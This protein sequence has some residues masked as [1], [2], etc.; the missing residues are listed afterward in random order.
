MHIIIW[1][2][3]KL[4][5]EAAM[6]AALALVNGKTFRTILLYPFAWW[7]KRSGNQLEQKLV[8]EAKQDLHIDP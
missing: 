6:S 7:A 1:A 8:E 3:L 5:G 2:I 4:L